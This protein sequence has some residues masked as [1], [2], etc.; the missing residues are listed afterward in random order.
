VDLNNGLW[1]QQELA[2]LIAGVD[3]QR[4]MAEI[5]QTVRRDTEEVAA[6]LHELGLHK[7]ADTVEKNRRRSGARTL[8]DLNKVTR[9]GR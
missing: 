3:Y 1:T 2:D 5:A 4:T 9:R 6:K 8:G 7:T